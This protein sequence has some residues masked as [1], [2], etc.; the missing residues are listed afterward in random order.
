MNLNELNDQ[1]KEILEKNP[2]AGE[3]NVVVE[4]MNPSV[5]STYTPEVKSA[6]L[7]FDWNDGKFILFPNE[8]MITLDFASKMAIK[9][10]HLFKITSCTDKEGKPKFGYYHRIGRIVGEPH[11]VNGRCF[12]PYILD[13]KGEKMRFGQG[14]MTS[15]MVKIE[16]TIKGKMMH[17][18]LETENTIYQL[19]EVDKEE[20]YNK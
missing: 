20:V 10:N 19:D 9:E 7:G 18:V 3:C 6:G 15:R 17:I 11:L 1:I 12:M 8:Q 4:S 2:N 13:N 5:G 14:L 16:T